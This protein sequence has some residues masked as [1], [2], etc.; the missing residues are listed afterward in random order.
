MLM[1]LLHLFFMLNK[2]T[3]SYANDVKYQDGTFFQ[4]F[5]K[6]EF[7]LQGRKPFIFTD[8]AKNLLYIKKT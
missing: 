6:T 8:T 5:E 7:Y 2:K 4:K 3:T 1:L